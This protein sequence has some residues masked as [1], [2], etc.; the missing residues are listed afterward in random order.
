[1]EDPEQRRDRTV[2][3]PTRGFERRPP[4]VVDRDL[5]PSCAGRAAHDIGRRC[6]RFGFLIR[7]RERPNRFAE[8]TEA[9]RVGLRDSVG[10]RHEPL[11]SQPRLGLRRRSEAIPLR[12]EVVVVGV[13]EALKQ[14]EPP[15][16]LGPTSGLDL[17]TH[18]SLVPLF[19][20]RLDSGVDQTIIIGRL[21]STVN[22]PKPNYA[23]TPSAEPRL[24]RWEIVGAWLHI[25]TPPKGVEVP[26]VP[27]RKLALA[28]GASAVVI[29]GV[30]ALAVPRIDES[31][32][33]GAAERARQ[34]AAADAV[35]RARL[36]ADQRVHTTAAPAGADLVTAL[37]AAVTA[38]AKGRVRA[39]TITGPV[40]STTCNPTST[41]VSQ[42]PQ[43][44]V[45]KC[46]VKTTTGLPGEDGDVIGTGYPFV[47]TIYEKDR[48]LAWCKQNPHADEKGMRGD[49]RV[50]MSPVCAGKLSQVL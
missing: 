46:F 22:E 21:V 48:R 9:R 6:I 44:H 40:L 16:R 28:G 38:D 36:R 26:P 43:S 19:H 39:K 12:W 14:L 29:A 2:D 3:T 47:A 11:A 27:W 33:K 7:A 49:V 18:T 10:W 41:A 23:S 20:D 32:R 1:M 45:Y 13:D 5:E 8:L 35:E 31:K 30:A 17:L 24:S 50:K 34:A 37:E 25:W 4:R 42:F 15:R